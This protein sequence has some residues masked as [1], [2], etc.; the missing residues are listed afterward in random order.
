MSKVLATR[1]TELRHTGS[2]IA[3]AISQIK[4]EFKINVCSALVTDNAGNMVVAAK[5]LSVPH[6]S[7]FPIHCS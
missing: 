5:E 1:V 6:V 2:N 4:E 3:L 7:C